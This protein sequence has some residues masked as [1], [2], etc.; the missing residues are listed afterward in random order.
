MAAIQQMTNLTTLW[1]APHVPF[2]PRTGPKRGSALGPISCVQ[3]HATPRVPV[4]VPVLGPV[5]PCWALHL[6]A[7]CVSRL[8]PYA[9]APGSTA[10]RAAARLTW[11]GTR[12]GCWPQAARWLAA[13]RGDESR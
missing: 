4:L 7:L 13:W 5:P 2:E 9:R 6:A 12:R 3:R 10:T 8:Q 11:S 1:C